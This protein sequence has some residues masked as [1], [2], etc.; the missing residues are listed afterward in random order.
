MSIKQVFEKLDKAVF[1]L[2]CTDKS[3]YDRLDLAIFEFTLLKERD[4]PP[5][6]RKD[7]NQVIE[8]IQIYQNSK[9]QSDLQ[10]DLASAILQIFKKF[11]GFTQYFSVVNT[12]RQESL[13]TSISM[14]AG[15]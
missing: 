9:G 1:N 8:K 2:A 7:F 11:I 12:I 5:D 10:S 15:I 14:P 6:L 13:L 3:F 4:L